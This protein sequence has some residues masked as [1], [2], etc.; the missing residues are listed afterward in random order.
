METPKS[1]LKPYTRTIKIKNIAVNVLFDEDTPEEQ[2]YD[3]AAYALI[4]FFEKKI[5]E[6]NLSKKTKKEILELL[7]GQTVTP[8]DIGSLYVS[9]TG[10]Q[11]VY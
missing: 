10:R 3:N 8:R 5:N 9:A 1:T 6:L 7:N 4:Y 11:P 2:I